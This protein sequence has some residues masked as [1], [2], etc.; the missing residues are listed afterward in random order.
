MSQ[1]YIASVDIMNSVIKIS[2]CRKPIQKILKILEY[3]N[4][5]IDMLCYQ[6]LV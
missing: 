2:G 3:N 4:L 5:K 1:K 6:Y